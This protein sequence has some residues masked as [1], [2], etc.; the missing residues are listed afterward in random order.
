MRHYQAAPEVDKQLGL[1]GRIAD[2]LDSVAR[3]PVKLG[4]KEE[5]TGSA[6][7]RCVTQSIPE[8]I[9]AN[10]NIIRMRYTVRS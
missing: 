2:D 3:T 9:R 8:T 1:G 7:R 10:S 5:A 4:R 6:R